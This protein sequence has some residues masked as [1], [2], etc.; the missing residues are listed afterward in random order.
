MIKIAKKVRYKEC[1][2][3]KSRATRD[4]MPLKTTGHGSFTI[5]RKI[6]FPSYIWVDIAKY[7]IVAFSFDSPILIE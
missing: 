2:I 5:V 6:G 4:L 7:F 1:I 3:M